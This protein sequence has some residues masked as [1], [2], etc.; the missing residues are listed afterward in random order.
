MFMESYYNYY[1]TTFNYQSINT[2]V[3]IYDVFGN[4]YDDELEPFINTTQALNNVM[5]VDG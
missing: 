2:I 5:K 1:Q 3:Y 4:W